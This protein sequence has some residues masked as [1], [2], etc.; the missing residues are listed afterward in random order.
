MRDDV[1]M[2]ILRNLRIIRVDF[3][4]VV[5]T[6]WLFSMTDYYAHSLHKAKEKKKK[7]IKVIAMI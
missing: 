3:Y 4:G 5:K 2:A 7:K 6:I 1:N